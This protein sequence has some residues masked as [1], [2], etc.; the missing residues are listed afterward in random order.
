MF[1]DYIQSID[2]KKIEVPKEIEDICEEIIDSHIT[3]FLTNSI[4]KT[5]ID[6][7]RIL[8]ANTSLTL[9]KNKCNMNK[10][11]IEGRQAQCDKSKKKIE[12]LDVEMGKLFTKS[13]Q[14]EAMYAY[15]NKCLKSDLA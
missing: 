9:Y 15:Y 4:I 11:M 6:I 1:K 7:L 2:N 10:N 13:K 5:R 12:A 8:I 3:Y 14:L